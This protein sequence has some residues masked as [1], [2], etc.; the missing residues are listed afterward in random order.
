MGILSRP[1]TAWQSWLMAAV[2]FAIART[3]GYA[4]A[5]F[6]VCCCN[7]IQQSRKNLSPR[8]N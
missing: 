1:R 6:F 2:R 8:C 7:A 3:L 4:A 5:E